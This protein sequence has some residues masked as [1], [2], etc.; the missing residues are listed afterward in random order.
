MQEIII[1]ETD[2][3]KDWRT[4]INLINS[5]ALTDINSLTTHIGDLTALST[6]NKS[7]LVSAIN[8]EFS[9]R[10]TLAT[11]V[12]TVI[13]NVGVISNL[14]T[15]AKSNI[16]AA[17]NENHNRID[18]NVIAITAVE[19]FIANIPNTEIGEIKT[20]FLKPANTLATNGAA[21]SRTT[22]SG[23]FNII[24]T[25]FGDG[26]GTTTFN[27]PVISSTLFYP[28]KFVD[29]VN[30]TNTNYTA[31]LLAD[32]RILILY[33][34]NLTVAKFIT[35]ET[36]TVT[37]ATGIFV[38]NNYP[39]TTGKPVLLP[40][41]RVLLVGGDSSF[42]SIVNNNITVTPAT[43]ILS[44]GINNLGVEIINNN[45]TIG[46]LVSYLYS[47]QYN[48]SWHT[49]I[50][51]SYY[52]IVGDVITY[53]NNYTI[54]QIAPGDGTGG[55]IYSSL[56]KDNNLLIVCGDL[57][58]MVS[59]VFNNNIPTY[60]SKQLTYDIPFSNTTINSLIKLNDNRI[61]ITGYNFEIIVITPPEGPSPG[62][63]ETTYTF[64]Q[65]ILSINEI[66][67]ERTDNIKTNSF[68]VN[69]NPG[70]VTVDPSYII[71][72]NLILNDN[73]I[74]QLNGDLTTSYIRPVLG[75]WICTGTI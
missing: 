4:K 40:D 37:V 35:I 23:L 74:I 50:H 1:S 21:I 38:N 48:F 75:K 29:F 3:F 28:N 5:S 2:K 17:I 70:L 62:V 18:N 56:L 51:V 19:D 13:S 36:A 32:D 11:L 57:G 6:T 42:L 65:E 47:Q 26:D 59:L 8:E 52:T 73:S 9:L 64:F 43:D 31:T 58:F 34:D 60:S 55:V 33:A 61:L 41:G 27:I 22:Y 30:L 10:Y 71:V 63:Y 69:V 16:V 54:Q 46:L 72:N 15:T 53:I 45:G 39:T 67:I 68:T 14:L 7:N 24:N 66:T 12:N 20:S 25:K 49:N 44:G